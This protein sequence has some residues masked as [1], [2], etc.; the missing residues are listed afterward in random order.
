MAKSKGSGI[1][2]PL[3][4]CVPLTVVC[5]VALTI[6]PFPVFFKPG[7]LVFNGLNDGLLKR[8]DCAG[9]CAGSSNDPEK[10][11]FRE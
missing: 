1:K 2:F 5:G 8:E 3:P 4:F 11:S 7:F 10:E 9:H 6:G